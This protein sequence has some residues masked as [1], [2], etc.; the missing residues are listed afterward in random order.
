[1]YESMKTIKIN[2]TT[3]LTYR[4]KTELYEL[5][6][7]DAIVDQLDAFANGKKVNKEELEEELPDVYEELD[8]KA[9]RRAH[10]L[11]IIDGFK[12][13]GE[14]Y[15]ADLTKLQEMFEVSD[16][17][18]DFEAWLSKEDERIAQMGTAEYAEYLEKVYGVECEMVEDSYTFT[19]TPV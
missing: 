5:E 9:Y 19:Y 2:L 14:C 13:C 11:L 15:E 16:F 1:M 3:Y 8:Y 17:D 4:D 7:E 6:L 12:N 18:G 10:D